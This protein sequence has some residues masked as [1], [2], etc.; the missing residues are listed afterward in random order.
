MSSK[1]YKLPDHALIGRAKHIPQLPTTPTISFS[2]L[3][4]TTPNRPPNY[5]IHIRITA[6]V[7]TNTIT[8]TS[9]ETSTST[10]LP[11]ILLSHGQG[12]SNHLSSLNGYGP[13]VEYYASHG[14]VVIQ[15]THLSSKTL[16]LGMKLAS[17]SPSPT[18]NAKE[19]PN[20]ALNLDFETLG[21]APLFWKSRIHDFT[22]ILDA[23]SFIDASFPALS[24]AGISLDWERVGIVGHSMGAHTASMLLGASY[25]LNPESPSP[26]PSSNATSASISFYDARIK[27]GILIGAPGC[28]APDGSTQTPMARSVAP[29]FAHTDFSSMITPAL[30]VYGDADLPDYLTT[31]GME[32]HKD[33]YTM[34]PE[35]TGKEMLTVRGAGHCFGG[36]SGWDARETGE[37]GESVEMV[38]IVQRMTGAWMRERL[39]F[40]C[41]GREWEEA[42]GALEGLDGVGMVERK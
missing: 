22:D 14:F 34:A 15:P 13:L 4:L 2:P 32:W 7:I 9:S 28:D 33:P 19:D 23:H 39:R 42:C 29:F 25:I 6:P 10:S 37:E 31:R 40:N 16:S 35:G 41:G 26:S 12:S 17:A 38:G 27:A 30:I 3:I 18:T 21:P 1:T 8:K 36:V 24:Q 5:P 11:I 20:L